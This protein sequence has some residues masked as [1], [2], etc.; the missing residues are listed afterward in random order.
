[1]AD[2]ACP[3]RE[4]LPA[5]SDGLVLEDVAQRQ[6]KPAVSDSEPANAPRHQRPNAAP[7]GPDGGPA[8][9]EPLRS[10]HTTSFSAIL[11]E[12]R[13]SVAVSTYQAGRLVLLR[14]D[15]GLLNTHFR[16]FPKPMGMAVRGGRLAIGTE[17]EICEYH[18]TPAVA[19]K[20]DPPD[21]HDACFLPRTVHATGDVQI[22][23]M[24][25]VPRSASQQIQA[26]SAS[27]EKV[28][29]SVSEDMETR[30]VSEGSPRPRP[31]PTPPLPTVTR[32]NCGSST[33]SS[34]AWPPG[35]PTT[36]LCRG[37]GHGSSST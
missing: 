1:M 26:R 21:K 35:T 13:S 12:L 31:R 2:S 32:P 8:G 18:N 20:L 34:L 15:Q 11:N 33:P 3:H 37:G 28:T 36:A 27:E 7:P 9:L 10:V 17:L 25:W 6:A 19:R 5:L 30:S 14:S 22:H 23:E 29:R 4:A 24:A 16:C